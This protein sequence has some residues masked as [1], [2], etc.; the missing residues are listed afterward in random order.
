MLLASTDILLFCFIIVIVK[1]TRISFFFK[2]VHII[3]RGVLWYFW[4][5][6]ASYTP[7]EIIQLKSIYIKHY[8]IV[9]PHMKISTAFTTRIHKQA[10]KTWFYGLNYL[11]CKSSLKVMKI[12]NHSFKVNIEMFFI[13]EKQWDNH[14]I[15]QKQK[16]KYCI[17]WEK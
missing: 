5:L 4:F 7:A 15:S 9:L 11:S 12:T 8:D 3:Q 14:W 16:L 13:I 17:P 2:K 10:N 1:K 6:T